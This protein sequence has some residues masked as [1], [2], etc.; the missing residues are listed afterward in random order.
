MN[1]QNRSLNNNNNNNT[2]ESD[3]PVSCANV[4]FVENLYANANVVVGNE[5]DEE[6]VIC[7]N[8]DPQILKE[9]SFVKLR[10]GVDYNWKDKNGVSHTSNTGNACLFQ[11]PTDGSLDMGKCYVM[12]II[13]NYAASSYP[14]YLLDDAK[15]KACLDNIDPS[16]PQ[17]QFNLENLKI[18]VFADICEEEFPDYYVDLIDGTLANCLSKIKRC[19]EV[20]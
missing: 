7:D 2:P 8:L 5:C 14:Y 13:G 4:S 17:W 10:R 1:Q 6:I 15:L 20:K 18:P 12:E 3:N 11:Q 19:E 9:E 16:K